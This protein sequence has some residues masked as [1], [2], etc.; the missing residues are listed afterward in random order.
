[1]KSLS[2]AG[3]A[4]AGVVAA[5]DLAVDN[6]GHRRLRE[7]VDPA[8]PGVEVEADISPALND[9]R[10]LQPG[11]EPAVAV[12][13]PVYEV[14]SVDDQRAVPLPDRGALAAVVD[15]LL[16]LD[17]AGDDVQDLVGTFFKR[18]LVLVIV[19]DFGLC[20]FMMLFPL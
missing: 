13:L 6:R 8:D 7:P 5:H 11:G 4:P 1:M 9:P 14:R 18:A 12:D 20:N 2:A 16:G 17:Q 15:P 3:S 10:G 19:F